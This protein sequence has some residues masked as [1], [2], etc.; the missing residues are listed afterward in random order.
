MPQ[1]MKREECRERNK[2]KHKAWYTLKYKVE[3]EKVILPDSKEL[4]KQW[5]NDAFNQ[6]TPHGDVICLAGH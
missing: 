1:I 3:F 4:I 5:W 2:Q 6:P